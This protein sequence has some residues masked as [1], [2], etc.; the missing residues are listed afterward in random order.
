MRHQ[1]ICIAVATAAII[2]AGVRA[3][4]SGARAAGPRVTTL[5]MQ[6][7]RLD[8]DA[9]YSLLPKA[10]DL[11]DGDA[12]V[13]YNK[14]VDAMPNNFNQGQVIEWARLP[15]D[16]LPQEQVQAVL[17]RAQAS[18]QFV[19]EGALCKN[20]VWPPFQ[21]GTMPPNL[22]KYRQLGFLMSLKVRLEIAQKQ[23]DRAVGTMRTGM[24]MA[25]HVGEA[26][27][28]IQGMVGIAMAAVMLRGVDELTQ[29]PGSPNLYAA[30][31]ALPRPFID[32]EKPIAEELKALDANPRYALVRGMM[33]K[34]MEEAYVRVRQVN[35]R[36][37][38]LIAAHQCVQALR[39]YAATHD[40]QLP[41]QLADITDATLPDDPL[42]GKPFAYHLE[43]TKAILDVSAPEGG[44]PREA[45]R[46]EM[47]IAR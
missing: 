16:Q 12:A 42:S 3:G 31:E 43:G 32:I 30:I 19:A 39:H 37:D 33:R 8:N 2:P 18:L 14:A 10:A 40:N 47:E 46:Y 26:P 24:A 45:L 36:T 17:Q 11:T 41:A 4:E 38:A 6:A 5:A 23:Y 25:R 7:S 34:Q 15:L 1:I 44:S 27:T 20:C 22:D 13:L 9:D 29:A 21:A 28:I 35:Q